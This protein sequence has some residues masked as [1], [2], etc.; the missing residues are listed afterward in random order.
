MCATDL[1]VDEE[2]QKRLKEIRN[3]H[4]LYCFKGDFNALMLQDLI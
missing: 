2:D 4:T 1:N 3:T